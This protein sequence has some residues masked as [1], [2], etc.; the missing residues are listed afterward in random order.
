MNAATGGMCHSSFALTADLAKMPVPMR[1]EAA[2]VILPSLAALIYVFSALL[3]KRSSD[4]GVGLTRTTFMANIIA[5]LL[6]SLLWLLGGKDVEPALIW[7][8][9]VIALCLFVG[10]LCQFLALSAAMFRWPCRC[11]A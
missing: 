3:L 10:Q 9:T 11:S 4:H 1:P 6:F 7:Q 8:P 2:L 5:A